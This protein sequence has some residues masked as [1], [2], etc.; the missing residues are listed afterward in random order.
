MFRS[1]R[2]CLLPL[3][4]SACSETA[5]DRGFLA[6]VDRTPTGAL[7]APLRAAGKGGSFAI[8]ALPPEA[9]VRGGLS[10]RRYV[11]GWRQSV[12]LDRVEA[13]NGWN[14]LS[15]DIRMDEPAGR[16]GVIPMGKPTRD[17]VR[18]EILARFPATDM[19]IVARP[20]QNAL[21]PFGL[22]VGAGS[23]GMRCAFAWQWVDDLRKVEARNGDGDSS[24]RRG[25][26]LPASIRMRLCRAG[27]TA[28]DLAGWFERLEVTDMA[29]VERIVEAAR[30]GA[31]GVAV[32][33][34]R[35]SRNSGE[36]VELQRP[37]GGG[38]LIQPPLTLES[39][40]AGDA[41]A[42]ARPRAA[43]TRRVG[44]RKPKAAPTPSEEAPV[45]PTPAD[46]GR[47]YLAPVTRT[48]EYV[49]QSSSYPIATAASR[50][51]PSLPAQAYNGPSSGL[52]AAR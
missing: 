3:A 49:G 50:L 34:L 15:I 28:D 6:R 38:E 48:P 47:R 31:N 40:V 18:R 23:G 44:A 13:A 11:N 7:S 46:G 36:F 8:L 43:G 42:T 20:M 19:R 5:P 41:P 2:L 4:L 29:N 14:D 33:P 32:E 24:L 30:G 45:S 52:A 51:D 37:P 16:D 21:G 22:A 25:K 9:R 39:A 35:A 17:G 27:V 1:S 12:A 10:E 26:E